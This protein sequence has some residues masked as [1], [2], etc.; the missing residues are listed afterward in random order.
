MSAF[1]CHI[2]QINTKVLN[3]LTARTKLLHADK[4]RHM[5]FCRVSIPLIL[6][7]LN[8]KIHTVRC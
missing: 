4:I 1:S 7:G 8:R 2:V 6:R 3:F 5:F